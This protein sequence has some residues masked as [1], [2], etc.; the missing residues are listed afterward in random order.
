MAWEVV[1]RKA[2]GRNRY[3]ANWHKYPCVSVG[4][5]GLAL[6]EMAQEVFDL[7]VGCR[8]FVLFDAVRRII[9]IKK[10]INGEDLEGAYALRRHNSNG[11][12]ASTTLGCFCSTLTKRFSDCHG[13]AYRAHL[14][15]GERII[16]VSLS[17]ENVV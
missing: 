8:V 12:K 15:P 11:K 9:G 5:T 17:P 10:A 4:K 2:S 6:N 16:E 13:R 3:G 1:T 14:N 7:K